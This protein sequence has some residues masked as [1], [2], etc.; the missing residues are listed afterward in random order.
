MAFTD[1]CFCVSYPKQARISS[2]VTSM[3]QRRIYQA[4]ICSGVMSGSEQ[5][6]AVGLKRPSGHRTS[7][8]LIGTGLAPL[9]HQSAV[10][11]VSRRGLVCLVYHRT[12]TRSQTVALSS[13]LSWR[14]GSL[15][16]LW[17]LGPRLLLGARGGGA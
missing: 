16:P 10:P 1:Q 4:R 7:T 13:S 11:E 2:K 14:L 6:R 8:H 5:K 15:S 9:R 17:G 12:Q 3:F